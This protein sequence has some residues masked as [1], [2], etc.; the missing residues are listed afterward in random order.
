MFAWEQRLVVEHLGQNAADAP[1]VDRLVVA[2][3]V[4]HDL[5]RAV[6]SRGHV[7]GEETRV[8]VVGVGDSCQTKVADLFANTE[9]HSGTSTRH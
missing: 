3:R 9:R 7:L 6:P 1:N 4:E 5:R 2:L 8:V